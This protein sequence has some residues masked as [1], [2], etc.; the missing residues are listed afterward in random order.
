[1]RGLRFFVI[2]LA[3]LLFFSGAASADEWVDNG[4]VAVKVNGLR[5]VTS[6]EDLGKLKRY[7]AKEK[8]ENKYA[9]VQEGLKNQEFKIVLV[10]LSLKNITSEHRNLGY[11]MHLGG[12]GTWSHYGGLLYLRSSDGAEV[13]SANTNAFDYKSY[14]NIPGKY[15]ASGLTYHLANGL[16]MSSKV[17]PGTVVEGELVFVVPDWFEPVKIFSKPCD[18][19]GPTFY[20][21]NQVVA[22]VQ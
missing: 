15:A 5:T 8:K 13:N 3:A 17:A 2:S 12:G 9:K 11:D 19:S 21:K 20:G 7:G 4:A 18:S 1:M 14:D 6:W 16:P 10:E 22:E